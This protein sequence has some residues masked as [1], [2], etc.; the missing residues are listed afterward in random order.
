MGSSTQHSVIRAG[1]LTPHLTPG[2][3]VEFAA[4]GSGRIDTHVAHVARRTGNASDPASSSDLRL[5]TTPAYLDHATKQLLA[6]PLDVIGYASTTSAYVIGFHAELAMVA[7]L[8]ESSGL[9]VAATCCAAV[10]ALRLLEVERV[11][12]VG[13]PW[14]APEYNELGAAYFAGQGFH[15]VSS[16]S[17]ELARH[18][19][20]ITPAAVRDWAS[21]HVD[22]AAEAVFIGG[23]GF[24]AA[25]AIAGLEAELGR[26]VLTSNQVLL[27]QL[28][29]EVDADV[30]IDGYGQLFARQ[31]ERS[32]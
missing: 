27:W 9:P 6:D 21:R 20:E 4:M 17:A 32:P 7:R 22:D 26:P 15:V 23:N 13:A 10:R 2:P 8:A 29:A 3:E 24:R 28:L 18:P 14:F 16:Q 31:P 30:K 1:V 5:R 11:A 25:G 19:H 12:L